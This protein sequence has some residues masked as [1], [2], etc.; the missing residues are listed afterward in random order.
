VDRER[1]ARELLDLAAEALDPVA[2]FEALH[3][4]FSCALQRADGPLARQAMDEM[5]ELIDR[6]G[7]VGRRWALLYQEAA[8]AH[9]EDR[10][11]DAEASAEA[12]LAVFSPV[13]PSRAMAAYG[14]QLLVLRWAQGRISELTELLELMVIDQPAV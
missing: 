14:G 3:L 9:L 12:A 6:T 2:R 7:A 4:V 10:L 13:S 11:D 8:L 1:L 5:T